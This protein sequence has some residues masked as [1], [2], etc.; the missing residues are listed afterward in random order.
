MVMVKAIIDIDCGK[1]F[2]ES[3]Q[4]LEM[5]SIDMARCRLFKI[6]IPEIPYAYAKY[7]DWS[8]SFNRCD[9]CLAAEIKGDT[10]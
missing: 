5:E 7:W 6:S 8:A 1:T 2:C 4:Y 3:C 9:E 10:S